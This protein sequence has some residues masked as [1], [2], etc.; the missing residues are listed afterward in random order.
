M[1]RIDSFHQPVMADEAVDLLKIRPDGIYIDATAGGGG[2]TYRIV[3]RLDSSGKVF[4]IDRDDEAVAITLKRLESFGSRVQVIQG[5]FGD[6]KAL[7][8]AHGMTDISGV[9]FDLGVS[10]WQ[11]DS[12]E[13]G[14]TYRGDGPLDFRMDRRTETTAAD[15][16]NSYSEKQLADA[17]FHYGEEKN[18]RKVAYA[19]VQARR[20]SPI[21]TTGELARVIESVTNPRYVNKSLSR[22]FQAIRIIVNEELEQLETGL[23]AS[24]DI[25]RSGGRLVVVSYHSLEDRIVKLFMRGA[26]KGK[27]DADYEDPMGNYKSL[28]RLINKKPLVPSSEEIKENPRARSAK[29]RVME[30]L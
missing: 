19:I 25:L 4:A 16:I 22:C 3:S 18:S 26:V 24:F 5:A 12:V 15:I 7:A 27:M 11:F 21:K 2:Y 8:L 6:L 30:K 10:S 1:T 14:F 29:L 28:A 13:R 23:R 20:K 9:I 17:L